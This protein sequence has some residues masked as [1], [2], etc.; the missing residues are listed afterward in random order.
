MSLGSAVPLTGTVF[1]SIMS[2]PKD[3]FALVNRTRSIKHDTKFVEFCARKFG[4]PV[5]PNERAGTWYVNPTL[6]THGQSVYFKSTDGHTGQCDFS[7][8]RM[9]L[10]ILDLI[11]K[12]LGIM[13]VDTTKRGKRFPDS[14]SKTI[15]IWCAVLNNAVA[16]YHSLNFPKIEREW[17][18]KFH[19]TTAAVSSSESSLISDQIPKFV[20]KLMKTNVDIADLHKLIKKP[21][22]PIW[23]HP[24]T[25]MFSNDEDLFWSQEELN[26]LPFIPLILVSA[27]VSQSQNIDGDNSN[28]IF[29]I[30]KSFDYVQGAA[31][32]TENWSP[33]LN[34]TKFWNIYDKLTDSI[35]LAQLEEMIEDLGDIVETDRKA[36]DWIGESGIAIGC[37]KAGDPSNCWD[38]F[39]Y[40]INC[41]A[42]EFEGMIPEKYLFLDIAEGKKGK[43]QLYNSFSIVID[44]MKTVIGKKILIHCMQG[45]DRSIGISLALMLRYMMPDGTLS[46]STPHSIPNANLDII[47]KTEVM[48][49]L[50]LIK[51]YRP[52]ANPTRETM[53]KINL[54]FI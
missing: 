32:D 3:N 9:N 38:K 27:S 26:E 22:R 25:T 28:P 30:P 17:D 15:P 5:V 31:D 43:Q 48:N 51:K 20:Q 24:S 12:S 35:S 6:R 36:F 41:G 37:R 19:S 18:L 2:T 7:L 16:K 53:K 40:V 39:D 1:F 10:Q 11:S 23:I 50:L 45:I 34:A 33:S 29:P 44:K 13:I 52:K 42:K 14:L 46:A 4:F 49:M 21:L 54:Y 47:Q 8:K